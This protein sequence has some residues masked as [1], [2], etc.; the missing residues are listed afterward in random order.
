[1]AD[2]PWPPVEEPD[3]LHVFG[4][5]LDDKPEMLKLK[6]GT[7]GRKKKSS[8]P[9]CLT[10]RTTALLSLRPA[11][12][13]LSKRTRQTPKQA[14]NVKTRRTQMLCSNR[15]TAANPPVKT[16]KSSSF[17]RNADLSRL[18]LSSKLMA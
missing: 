14:R 15:T 18:S 8:P 10:D 5:S 6:E 3:E 7:M 12:P 4:Y 13:S 2:L 17:R 11:L 9:L 1:L 16:K